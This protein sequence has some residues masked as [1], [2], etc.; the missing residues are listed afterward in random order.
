[1]FRNGEKE[2]LRKARWC[3]RAAYFGNH[4]SQLRCWKPSPA[5]LRREEFPHVLSEQWPRSTGS[6]PPVSPI[7]RAKT[8]SPLAIIGWHGMGPNVT[9][10]SSEAVVLRRSR[11]A[12]RTGGA[13]SSITACPPETREEVEH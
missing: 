1:M 13:K 5:S 10:T 4:G 12:R 11:K 9:C 8:L 6:R 3:A 2:D 7:L